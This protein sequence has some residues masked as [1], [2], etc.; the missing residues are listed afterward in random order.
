MESLTLSKY[1]DV[2]LNFQTNDQRTDGS[3]SKT[4]TDKLE[5]RRK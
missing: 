4:S 1:I 2:F 5:F 3:Q